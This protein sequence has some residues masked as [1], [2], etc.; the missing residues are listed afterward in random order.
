MAGHADYTIAVFQNSST[1]QRGWPWAN[2]AVVDWTVALPEHRPG[3]TVLSTAQWYIASAGSFTHAA[4]A[5]WQHSTALWQANDYISLRAL[6]LQSASVLDTWYDKWLSY[7]RETAL[8][9]GSV[10]AKSGRRYSADNI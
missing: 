3:A 10:L 2:W 7:R 4:R 8:Q 1:R 5:H 9:H 6:L